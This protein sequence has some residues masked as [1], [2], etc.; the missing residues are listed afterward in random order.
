MTSSYNL[1]A[2]QYFIVL[3]SHSYQEII[4]VSFS[5]L[6]YYKVKVKVAQFESL[7]PHAV[8]GILQARILEWVDIPFSRASSQPRDQTQIPHIACRFFTN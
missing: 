1:L 2:I 8:H 3:I 7:Q 6:F 4:R 5:H